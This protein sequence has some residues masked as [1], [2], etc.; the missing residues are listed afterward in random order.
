[1]ANILD[2]ITGMTGQERTAA[3]RDLGRRAE[4]YV[5][6]ELRGILGF[7]AEMTPSETLN[8]AAVAGGEMLAPGRTPMQRVGSAGRML[9]E[10]AGVAAPIAA[11]PRAGMTAAQSLQEGL[12][13][14][15]MAADDAGRRFVE[16]MNQPGPVPTMYSNPVGRA[17][18]PRP[19]DYQRVSTRLP[20][21]RGATE[22]P[23]TQSLISDTEAFLRNP[24]APQNLK[25]MTETYPGF[26]G[27]LS[28]DPKETA[29]NITEQMKG[30]II[31][32]YDLAEKSGITKESAKW[33]DGARR[34]SDE[35]SG[36]FNT[37]PE[38]AAGVLA[39]MSPQKDW[40]QN[41]ALAERI[42]KHL[43]E[44]QPSAAWTPQMDAHALSK[45]PDKK[46]GLTAWT[47][48]KLFDEV[49]G[50]P[51]GEMDTPEK[52]AM[53]LRAY[54]E[55]NFGS[56]FREI[57]PE[58]DVLDYVR[59]K[60]GSNATLV[61]QNFPNIAKAIRI[62]EGDGSLRSISDELGNEHKVRN[63]FNNILTPDSPF[64]VTADTHQIAGGLLM[65]YG[66]S[67]PEVLHGLAG[68]SVPQAGMPWSSTGGKDTGTSGAYGLY[69][70][71]TRR[72]AEEVGG[73]I[74]RQ[75]QSITWEQL[76]E[77][78]PST[79]RGNHPFV[80]T[81]RT[82]WRLK[83]EGQITADQA[84]KMIIEAA[85]EAGGGS[86]PSWADYTGPRRSIA[87]GA[88]ATAGLL[89]LTAAGLATAQPQGP[90]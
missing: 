85:K 79:I 78:M 21:G 13:G 8:R 74:P 68:Q 9:S 41:V 60:D 4:Y 45:A 65:P 17:A 56:S 81:A 61:H 82:I 36:R 53:W 57:S 54:D 22:D 46:T 89:G 80:N 49:R 31:S 76:R 59:K 87:K 48:S 51:W 34:I 69:Y 6:P 15:S 39:V 64:D 10:T 73:W 52:K 50:R 75:M 58:G 28:T 30:N 44:L 29:E 3:L 62:F 32:L 5:P 90:Q 1:M 7:A 43:S 84:R 26:R 14:F 63:F 11:G 55:A 27:L 18:T 19:E 35:L 77:L 12:L 70:D 33:Y 16:R 47:K 23:Y 38:K 24:S 66:S 71:A 83:D 67:A 20:S 25:M 88:G 72:A 37:T 86:R 2:A 40:Y 42:I